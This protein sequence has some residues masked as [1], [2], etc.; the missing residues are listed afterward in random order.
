MSE[1]TEL[2]KRLE[3]L[4]GN[5]K[6][7]VVRRFPILSMVTIGGLMAIAM[8]L[9]I[10]YNDPAPEQL[11]TGTPEEFQTVGSGFGRIAPN[12]PAPE[13]TQP[14]A[15][16]VPNTAHAEL[17]AQLGNRCPAQC[18]ASYTGTGC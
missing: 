4:E 11:P 13:P 14:I 3:A 17:I 12:E 2:K 8:I 9:F 16:S 10:S 7:L 5:D 6:T 18:T 1:A 15:P